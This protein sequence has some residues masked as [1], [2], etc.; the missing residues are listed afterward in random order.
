MGYDS[1]VFYD[2][3]PWLS[4]A[5]SCLLGLSILRAVGLVVYRLRFSP[6]AKFPG[7]RLAAATHWYEAYFDLVSRGGG[8]WTFQI[9]RLHEEYG[10]VVRINPDELHIDDPEYYDVI[11]G[12][13][14]PNRPIDKIE[15]FR[16][17][18]G[19]PEAT[20]Q[21]AKAEVHRRRRAA[22]APCFS[23]GRIRNR[24]DDL[25]R[26]LDRI[27]HRL[28]TEFSG[29]DKVLNVNDMWAAMA[30]DIITE[31][32][33]ARPTDYSGAPD[34]QSPFA[35][36]TA[37]MVRFGHLNTHFGVLASAMNWLPDAVLG[38]LVPPIRP[39]LAFRKEMGDQIQEILSG[40]NMDV[41][42]TSHLTIFHDALSADLPA[43]DL[44]YTRLQQEAMGV[45][46]GAV[47][48]T[49]W[50][51]TVT[52][53]HVL[54]SP[55]IK[56]QLR[57]ELETFM[58]DPTQILT[59]D[60]LE[61]L[62]YLSAVIM[63]GLRLSFGSVQRLPRVNRLGA[64]EYEQW[65]IPPNTPVSM[66]AYHIHTNEAIFPNP[67]AFRPER[68]LGD[69]TGPG[70]AHPLS[71]YMVSFGRGAR[72]CLGVNLAWMELYVALATILR[73]HDLE[74][75]ETGRDDVDFAV[76]LVRPMPKW[77]SK[78]VRVVVK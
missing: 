42:E 58:P 48:T 8:Q 33:F 68:W 43:E 29:T 20:V 12:N 23:R 40:K 50:A 2:P 56:S 3:R 26:I 76:D 19:V 44:T 54:H 47:E 59:W 46:G 78:G 64:L 1:L 24:N 61:E 36:A 39:I 52:L 17:R 31:I 74:L 71:H 34:F 65:K 75:F 73:R 28:E 14:S 15:K 38:M 21:S 9:K 77:N 55:S 62:P 6:V 41:K 57:A 37:K 10:P 49:S 53:F 32:A 69:P 27:S 66:D 5:V 72:N 16:Y 35:Q 67:S 4:L 13:S 22:I 45:N 30:S 7:P 11:Y 18:F 25:Q 51:L 63:E 60:E 70:G